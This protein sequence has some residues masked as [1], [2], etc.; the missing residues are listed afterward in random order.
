LASLINCG[1]AG[2]S[3]GRLGIGLRAALAAL[4]AVWLA[5]AVA[6]EPATGAR[7][8]VSLT[9]LSRELETAGAS[10]PELATLGGLNWLEGCAWDD[11]R[12]DVVLLGRTVPEL[13]ELRT[14]DLVVALRN[15]WMVY[16]ERRGDTLFYSNPGCSIDPDPA[17][18]ARL[19]DCAEK[20]RQAKTPQDT[21]EWK[22]L[23]R[24]TCAYPQQVRV[25]GIPFNTH[26]ARVMVDADYEMKSFVNGTSRIGLEGVPSLTALN[27]SASR[28]AWQANQP[29]SSGMSLNRFWFSPQTV[30]YSAEAGIA[31]VDACPVGLLTEEEYLSRGQ[32]A[33][34]GRAGALAQQF[35]EGFTGNYQEIAVRRPLYRELENLFRL[36]A[37]AKMLR[38]K[39][40]AAD[41]TY[42]LER[43]PVPEVQVPST[44][45]GLPSIAH[46][47][48][49]K[50]VPGGKET[51]QIWLPSCGGVGID[52]E[53]DRSRIVRP[54]GPQLT[55]LRRTVF[56]SRPS[57]A[58][59]R[60]TF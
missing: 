5:G 16:A 28:K 14:E 4:V 50:A 11:R 38:S 22:A 3:I 44:L 31:R 15:A 42:F 46:W 33:G 35:A 1:F 55:E 54:S 41:W 20:M 59:W 8:A 24:S 23:W 27:L 12:N 48:Q 49:E 19:Q 34:A 9:A 6:A 17:A 10:S 51:M 29:T 45:Q 7:L 47:T 13:P 39:T 43:Y 37:V 26:F 36:V 2:S 52:V 58:A 40:T 18:L 32:V 30:Q 53:L 25:L 21:E 56:A 57:P 60:W